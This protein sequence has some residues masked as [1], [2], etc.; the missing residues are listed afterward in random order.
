MRK[1]KKRKQTQNYLKKKEN[2]FPLAGVEPRPL[3]CL[4]STLTI[5][6]YI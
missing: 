3:I 4:V 5:Q 6:K 2:N 1:K